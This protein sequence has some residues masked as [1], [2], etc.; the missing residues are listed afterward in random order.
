MPLEDILKKIEQEAQQRQQSILHNARSE[1]NKKIEKAQIEI[2]REVERLVQQRL[3]EAQLIV[4]RLLA[5]AKLK[6][7]S[8]IGQVKSE[9]LK[10]VREEV[11][12]EFVKRIS[13]IQ[14]K[15]YTKIIMANSTTKNEEIFMGPSEANFLGEHFINELNREKKTSF[16][17]GGVTKEIDRGLLLKRD[18]MILNLSLNSLLD[19]IF[20]QNE[21]QISAMLFKGGEK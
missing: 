17:F 13:Q 2:N 19:D 11:A 20:R 18:G 12:S 8:L 15:W 7:R 5:E 9:A 4:Q 14:K 10:K 6:G 21:N 3:K 16:R 1:A